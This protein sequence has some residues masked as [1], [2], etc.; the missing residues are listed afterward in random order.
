MGVKAKERE[1]SSSSREGEMKESTFSSAPISYGSDLSVRDT[2]LTSCP[3][4][5]RLE[6]EGSIAE[7]WTADCSV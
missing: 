3:L 7:N 2:N 6:H 4:L 1:F 5:E